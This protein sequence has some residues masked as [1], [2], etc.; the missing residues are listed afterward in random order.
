M[1][2]DNRSRQA[3][4]LFL[5]HK[6]AWGS[7][8]GRC[9]LARHFAFP[10]V[11]RRISPPPLPPLTSHPLEP[12]S[13]TTP[14]LMPPFTAPHHA[15]RYRNS[16]PIISASCKRRDSIDPLNYLLAV[17]GTLDKVWGLELTT[18][19]RAG[20]LVQLT[21]VIVP[22]LEAL[23][24]RRKLKP[25]VDIPLSFR[26]RQQRKGV[27]G[28]YMCYSAAAEMLVAFVSPASAFRAGLTPRCW[29]QLWS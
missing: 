25:Q 13:F 28:H 7:T 21:T 9:F 12:S 10:W 19:S 6:L 18:A 8:S 14:Q 15:P 2:V 11:S 27:H 22:V 20:F 16:L 5:C 1:Y 3:R 29:L 17:G 24:G 23:I 26:P 4:P